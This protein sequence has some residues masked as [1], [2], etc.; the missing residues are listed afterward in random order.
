VGTLIFALMMVVVFQA[1]FQLGR[2]AQWIG[3]T[4][5]VGIVG[6][7]GRRLRLAD[8]PLAEVCWSTASSAANINHA[9]R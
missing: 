6:Q 5:G 2:P 3:S 4:K 9:I 8:G 1:V 7:N